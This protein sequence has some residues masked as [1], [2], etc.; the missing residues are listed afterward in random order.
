M[1]LIM[2]NSIMLLFTGVFWTIAY[3][4]CISIG[5]KH[6]TYSMPFAALAI[7]FAWECVYSVAF[8]FFQ[9][10]IL[11]EVIDILWLILDVHILATYFR[12]GSKQFESKKIFLTWSILIILTSFAIQGAFLLQFGFYESYGYVS[13][14]QNLYMSIAFIVMLYQRK[15]SE[16]QSLIIAITKFLGTF[17]ATIACF[18]GSLVTICGLLCAFFDIL[19]I[20]LLYKMRMKERV[21]SHGVEGH[22]VVST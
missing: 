9:D 2:F 18:P 7:N 1:I 6:K 20:I 11:Q 14:L 3:L 22:T 8:I 21:A 5:N 13:F 12:Y 4:G 19:Y 17:C 15:S 16:G 10:N